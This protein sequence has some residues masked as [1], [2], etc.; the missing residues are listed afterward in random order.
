MKNKIIIERNDNIRII[1]KRAEDELQIQFQFLFFKIW[2]YKH[3]CDFNNRS[4]I[5]NLINQDSK[6]QIR[7]YPIRDRLSTVSKTWQLETWPA[8]D[9]D[10]PKWINNILD[11]MN[12]E[13]I[14]RTERIK[15]AQDQLNRI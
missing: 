3:W 8:N 5:I 11:E 1:I 2:F 10:L 4:Y 6:S 14:K 13:E 15:A 12:A 9:F 7:Y